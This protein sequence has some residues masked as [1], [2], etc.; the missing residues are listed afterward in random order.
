MAGPSAS[1]AVERALR[2]G[3]LVTAV[4]EDRPHRAPDFAAE[5]RAMHQ[6][7]QALTAP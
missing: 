4:L 3:A 7:A 5:S 1:R 6:L 2:A